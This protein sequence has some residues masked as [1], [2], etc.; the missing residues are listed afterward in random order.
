MDVLVDSLEPYPYTRDFLKAGCRILPCLGYQRPW[1]YFENFRR[2][3]AENGPYEIL[4][5]HVHYFSGVVLT[6]GQWLKIPASNRA[7]HPAEDLKPSSWKRTIYRELHMF[8]LLRRSATHLL[9]PSQTSLD[10]AAI[11]QAA[12]KT[13]C[14]KI[15]YNGIDL[16]SFQGKVDR[17]EARRRFGF[18]NEPSPQA[19]LCGPVRA[20]QKSSAG[21]RAVAE[22]LNAGG[23]VAHFVLAGTHGSEL[24]SLEEAVSQ[25]RDVSDAS[26]TLRISPG[27]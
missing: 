6:I 1:Q 9:T 25:R 11:A 2:L 16:G 17:N 21:S 8:A 26:R 7:L 13:P 14:R 4:H 23:A 19:R 12:Y 24:T 15:I 5:S 22:R 3:Y 20:A 10:D 27:F 18:A